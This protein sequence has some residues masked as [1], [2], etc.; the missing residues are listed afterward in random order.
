VSAHRRGVEGGGVVG[1]C[2][3]HPRPNAPHPTPPR[4]ARPGRLHGAGV[5]QRRHP[6][7]QAAVA[8]GQAVRGPACPCAPHCHARPHPCTVSQ[9]GGERGGLHRQPGVPVSGATSRV[10]REAVEHGDSSVQDAPAP[11]SPPP[12]SC[13]PPLAR[14]LAYLHG[15]NVIHRDLK[16][17]NI[18][19]H[20]DPKVRRRRTLAWGAFSTSPPLPTRGADAGRVGE[21][22]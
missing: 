22:G 16:P 21:G 7:L 6:V 3:P 10:K 18:L 4:T 1:V 11:T 2:C 17:E 20:V 9:H 5:R 19:L 14:A 8:A 15:N 13:A 12:L